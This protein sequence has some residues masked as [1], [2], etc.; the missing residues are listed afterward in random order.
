MKKPREIRQDAVEIVPKLK[1]RRIR[2]RRKP[3]QRP[4]DLI[5]WS[6]GK[7]NVMILVPPP[8]LLRA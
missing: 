2:L 5:A 3:P 8:S 6:P 1:G 7:G 4:I